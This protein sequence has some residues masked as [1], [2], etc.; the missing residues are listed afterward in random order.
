MFAE[1]WREAVEAVHYGYAELGIDVPVGENSLR[2]GSTPIIFGAH[3]LD[4]G[5]ESKLPAD[6]I[7]YN[8]EQLREGY[9]WFQP[10][11]LALLQRFRVWDFSARN[12]QYL[13]RLHNTSNALHV[14]VGYVQQLSRVEAVEQ[15]ID[16]LFFGILTDRRKR[17][18]DALVRAGLNVRFLVGVF[19]DERDRWIARSKV[20]L[21]IHALNGALFEHLRVLYLLANRKAVVTEPGEPDELDP[22][23]MRGLE[24]VHYDRLIESCVKLVRDPVMRQTLADTG[25][26]IIASPNRRMSAILRSLTEVENRSG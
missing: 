12:V 16:V 10:R 2:P 9:P 22:E 23:L 14:P 3:H 24:I 5:E 21:N 8:F 11:Y 7:L 19:G 17:V 13:R 18:F 25:Y 15:D 20:V 1:S 4:E 6:A 26:G